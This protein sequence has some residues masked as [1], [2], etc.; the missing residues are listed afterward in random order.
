[1]RALIFRIRLAY[2]RL[3]VRSAHV[4][5]AITEAEIKTGPA[6]LA[7]YRKALS[8]FIERIEQLEQQR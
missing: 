3:R 5:I 6:R 4:D 2:L 7:V 8:D 1:M